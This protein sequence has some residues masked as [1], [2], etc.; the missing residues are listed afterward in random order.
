MRITFILVNVSKRS[1]NMFNHG[2]HAGM[3]T[4]DEWHYSLMNRHNVR[5]SLLNSC[6]YNSRFLN[7]KFEISSSKGMVLFVVYGA[8]LLLGGAGWGWAE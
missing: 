6:Q 5:R 2:K 8:K 7:F 3:F 4:M 1:A